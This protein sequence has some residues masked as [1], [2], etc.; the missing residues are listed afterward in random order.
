MRSALGDAGMRSRLLAAC[1]FGCVCLLAVVSNWLISRGHLT[2][3]LLLCLAFPA[4]YALAKAGLAAIAAILVLL[5]LNGV[6]GLNL[7][8]Y[9]VHGSFEALDICSVALIVLALVRRV[10][11]S[12]ERSDRYSRWL[13]AWSA[14]FLMVWFF[15]FFQGWDRGVP[16]LKA[17][18]YGRDF[19]FFALLAPLARSLV[20]DERDL[21][22]FVGVLAAMATVYALGEIVVS[23][24]HVSPDLVNARH[25]LKVG[26][27]TRVYSPMNDLVVLAFACSLAYALLHSGGRATMAAGIASVCG[28]AVVLQLTRAI[29]LGLL[30]GLVIAFVVWVRGN[31]TAQAYLRRRLTWA[32]TILV[33]LAIFVVSA[34]PQVLSDSSV[35]GRIPA[36]RKRGD[37]ARARLSVAAWSWLPA[38]G[39]DP[40]PPTSSR[41]DPQQRPRR[42]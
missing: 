12:H 19:L 24:G 37:V 40:L 6:P 28:A 11:G 18:L 4:A 9:N 30:V 35:H 23:L 1:A 39:G 8:N 14:L 17:A 34:A 15:A 21:L 27:V 7:A 13:L 38:S 5:T 41:L 3:A 22:R 31:S 20:K 36:K 25:T 42:L 16:V 33:A 26:P 2:L 29:Y 32:V 10:Y